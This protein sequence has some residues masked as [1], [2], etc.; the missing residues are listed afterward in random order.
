MVVQKVDDPDLKGRFIKKASSNSRGKKKKTKTVRFK[1]PL[2]ASRQSKQQAIAARKSS[3]VKRPRLETHRRR[4][5]SRPPSPASDID[6]SPSPPPRELVSGRSV[7]TGRN[8]ASRTGPAAS[9]GRAGT[10]AASSLSKSAGSAPA[11]RG[12]QR[13]E[14]PPAAQVID[15]TLG[16]EEE[17]VKPAFQRFLAAHQAEN[18]LEF[19][20]TAEA[21]LSLRTAAL[22]ADLTEEDLPKELRKKNVKRVTSIASRRLI[23]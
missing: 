11:G 6:M 17:D 2:E 13:R 21:L 8:I 16:E 4:G 10:A 3:A 14:P 15:L 5:A 22:K 23:V 20:K 19:A 7:A 12:T 18:G 9:S 1:S